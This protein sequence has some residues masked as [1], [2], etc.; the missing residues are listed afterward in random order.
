MN[1]VHF[2]W[3][4]LLDD[5]HIITAVPRG[6]K[7]LDFLVPV[8]GVGKCEWCDAIGDFDSVLRYVS[9]LSP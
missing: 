3:C 1:V 9:R 4:S 2:G 5:M 8:Y 7:K 6:G